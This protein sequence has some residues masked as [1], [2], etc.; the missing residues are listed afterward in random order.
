MRRRLRSRRKT[1][2]EDII[3]DVLAAEGG[4]K[5]TNHP[6]DR[7]GPTKWGITQRA[8][9]EALGHTASID[10]IRNITERE[11]RDFYRSRYVV[12]PRFHTLPEL[13]M[14]LVVDCGVNH[15]PARAAKWLQKAVGAQQ[16]G[17]VGPATL[18]ATEAQDYEETYLKICA[19]RIRLYG[20]LVSRDP[21]QAVFASGWNNRA[22]KWILRLVE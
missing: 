4:D 7:G 6:A 20:A 2:I 18:A 16:D 1:V 19:Y 21:K 3:T 5:F 17:V 14:P 9:S 12:S 10:D 22:A 13:L 15:G 11:A 8:W